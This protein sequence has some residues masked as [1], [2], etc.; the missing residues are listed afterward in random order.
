L[1]STDHA[2][3]LPADLLTETKGARQAEYRKRKQAYPQLERQFHGRWSERLPHQLIEDP[4][5]T[6]RH[7]NNGFLKYNEEIF[8]WEDQKRLARAVRR[9]ADRDVKLLVSNANHDSVRRLYRA[10]GT[11]VKLDRYSVIGGGENYRARTSEIAV[12][13]NY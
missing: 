5:Y 4:P 13:I 7:N 10:H 11:V 8:L 2:A 9:A 6:V 3:T 1:V 12:R